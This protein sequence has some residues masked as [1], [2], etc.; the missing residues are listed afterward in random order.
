MFLK[1][2]SSCYLIL[3]FDSKKISFISLILSQFNHLFIL[4]LDA[5][6]Y[7]EIKILNQFH[8]ANL[9]KITF[10]AIFI[11]ENISENYLQLIKNNI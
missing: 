5:L 7:N 3:L 8:K 10:F 4:I 11:D 6:I 1:L 9:I 2:N